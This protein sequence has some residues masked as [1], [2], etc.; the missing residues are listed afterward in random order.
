VV[1]EVKKQL[2]AQVALTQKRPITEKFVKKQNALLDSINSLIRNEPQPVMPQINILP[3]RNNGPQFKT[4]TITA[5]SSSAA[6]ASSKSKKQQQQQQQPMGGMGERSHPRGY[7][8]A[9]PS[10]SPYTPI[11]TPMHGAMESVV[12]PNHQGVMG[13]MKERNHPKQ[14]LSTSMGQKAIYK[15]EQ[16]AYD[17]NRVVKSDKKS[18]LRHLMEYNKHLENQ[19]QQFLHKLAIQKKQLQMLN[20]TNA[21]KKQEYLLERNINKTKKELF[22]LKQ[23]LNAPATN[24]AAVTAALLAIKKAPATPNTLV[25]T[26]VNAVVDGKHT[27]PAPSLAPSLAP[28][29]A[30][31]PV[32]SPAPAPMAVS[33]PAPVPAPEPLE[34]K[35]KSVSRMPAYL[36]N[37]DSQHR[38]DDSN[39]IVLSIRIVAPVAQ[40][41]SSSSTTLQLDD[42]WRELSEQYKFSVKMRE[43]FPSELVVVL[44]DELCSTVSNIVYSI[45]HR[46][47]VKKV[48]NVDNDL[49][50][51]ISLNHQ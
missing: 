4:V 32:P 40:V 2:P 5:K 39:E 26:N 21:D 43:V 20:S 49:Y 19:K 31:A 48:F 9:A 7:L 36:R 17:G 34:Y 22:Y 13:A 38:N 18:H 29:P 45:G 3:P 15:E 25:S 10:N 35:I 8:E 44:H 33:V 12:T 27:S 51:D 23:L 37:Y 28:S 50:N 30:P 46:T 1:I 11:T 24:A 42:K 41:L 47:I 14:Q 16:S 6:A